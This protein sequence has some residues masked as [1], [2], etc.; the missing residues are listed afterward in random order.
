M[1][2]TKEKIKELDK[3]LPII[4]DGNEWDYVMMFHNRDDIV[5]K[6]FATYHGFTEE[7]LE[8]YKVAVR[9]NLI[10]DGI[11][12]YKHTTEKEMKAVWKAY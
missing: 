10:K 9:D 4:Y 8:R 11:A 1:W 5:Y 6:N 2:V 12:I 3:L 7:A